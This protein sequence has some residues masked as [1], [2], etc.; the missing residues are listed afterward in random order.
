MNKNQHK[1]NYLIF[2]E[3]ASCKQKLFSDRKLKIIIK[4]IFPTYKKLI[5]NIIYK[6]KFN[7]IKLV[8]I[9]INAN[10]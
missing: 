10:K 8:L 6:L 9:K 1:L 4:N 5:T 3:M 2:V 7:K